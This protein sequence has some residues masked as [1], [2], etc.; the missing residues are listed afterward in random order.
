MEGVDARGGDDL[1]TFLQIASRTPSEAPIAAEGTTA[2]W[3][4]RKSREKLRQPLV[5]DPSRAVEGPSAGI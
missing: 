3:D 2:A 4:R 5:H 1:R